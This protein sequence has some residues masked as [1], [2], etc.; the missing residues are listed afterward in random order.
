MSDATAAPE[1]AD[2]WCDQILERSLKQIAGIPTHTHTSLPHCHPA[3][4]S[5]LRLPPPFAAGMR[6]PRAQSAAS[7]PDASTHREE[8]SLGSLSLSL[9][10]EAGRIPGPQRQSPVGVKAQA[11]ACAKLDH[12]STSCG[13]PWPVPAGPRVE[14]TLALLR[15]RSATSRSPWSE[16]PP[17]SKS[18]ILRVPPG[19][20][21]PFKYIA[22]CVISRQTAGAA[23]LSWGVASGDSFGERPFGEHPLPARS[24]GSDAWL[25]GL[26]GCRHPRSPGFLIPC[27][28]VVL[29]ARCCFLSNPRCET[30]DD[31]LS[32]CCCC[33]E[34][35]HRSALLEHTCLCA[36]PYCS[37][38]GPN[39]SFYQLRETPHTSAESCVP[40]LDGQGNCC[41]PSF[42]IAGRKGIEEERKRKWPR[43][44]IVT[45]T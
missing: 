6:S 20:G 24:D 29:P 26:P 39:N 11:P 40:F 21:R 8:A 17:A 5:P 22:T 2:A 1:A 44:N 15:P 12:V 4:R 7:S 18:E 34:G 16:A 14:K 30:S 27:R 19:M 35:R 3:P 13:V 9:S 38:R 32:C 43:T 41:V 31:R 33:C 36:N 10:R 45:A 37:R 28:G 42:L 25:A 23:P